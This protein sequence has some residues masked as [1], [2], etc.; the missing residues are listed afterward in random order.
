M[1]NEIENPLEVARLAAAVPVKVQG[2][3]GI[4]AVKALLKFISKDETRYALKFLGVFPDY[5]AAT[6]GMKLLKI[7]RTPNC[8]S[9]LVHGR[10]Y[11]VA[12]TGKDFMLVPEADAE[13]FPTCDAVIPKKE[14]AKFYF[15]EATSQKRGAYLGRV[16]FHLAHCGV[17]VNSDY[18][19]ALPD[20]SWE[21]Y[22][23]N[24]LCP[25]LCISKNM[26]AVLM[27]MRGDNVNGKGER[28]ENDY[29]PPKVEAPPVETPPAASDPIEDGYLAPVTAQRMDAQGIKP[30]DETAD[31]L[32]TC[33]NCEYRA[34]IGRAHV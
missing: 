4:E 33:T 30:G 8:F 18:V 13:Q 20:A 19:E 32:V 15:N 29:T 22:I 14:D 2:N 6:D 3:E 9:N 24:P 21:F 27:P 12:K 34:E 10:S 31:P 23:T 7:K 5:V 11:S 16:L 1:K 28:I 26:T 25:V 17:Q